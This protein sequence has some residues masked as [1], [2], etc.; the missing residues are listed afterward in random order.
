[1][2][3]ND[4]H[5]GTPATNVLLQQHMDDELQSVQF[6]QLCVC[7]PTVVFA[8]TRRHRYCQPRLYVVSVPCWH[9]ALQSSRLYRFYRRH[10]TT[11][12]WGAVR[13]VPFA[14]PVQQQPDGDGE[15][16]VV[17]A[18][19]IDPSRVPTAIATTIRA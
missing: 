8:T 5:V 12:M 9:Y 17:R 10:A 3:S 1:V 13:R 14:L 19:H 4:A 11:A 6:A 18:S 7:V 2:W 16:Y 15:G